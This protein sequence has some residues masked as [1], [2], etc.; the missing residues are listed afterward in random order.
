MVAFR[1]GRCSME[2]AELP[3]VVSLVHLSIAGMT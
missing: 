2:A 3:G 1:Y